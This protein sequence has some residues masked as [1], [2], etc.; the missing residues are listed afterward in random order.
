MGLGLGSEDWALGEGV[1]VGCRSV[2]GRCVVG[3]WGWGSVVLK[4]VL[5]L[6]VWKC[7]VAVRDWGVRCWVKGVCG[8]FVW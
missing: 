4:F 6:R 5:G 7:E 3:V 8:L 2:V 1:G